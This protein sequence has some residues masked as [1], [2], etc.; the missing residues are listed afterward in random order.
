M[1][2]PLLI[3]ILL[4][5][6]KFWL[7]GKKF[8]LNICLKTKHQLPLHF[9]AWNFYYG[10]HIKAQKE[11]KWNHLI[12]GNILW[13]RTLYTVFSYLEACSGGSLKYIYFQTELDTVPDIILISCWPLSPQ[14]KCA[15]E[16]VGNLSIC[17]QRGYMQ[18]AASFQFPL[19]LN[20]YLEYGY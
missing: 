11:E 4:L 20:F 2:I 12:C 10:T 8:D 17:D 5:G 6:P 14:V 16:S 9:Y 15:L 18:F 13:V 7:W 19:P 1:W 3:L